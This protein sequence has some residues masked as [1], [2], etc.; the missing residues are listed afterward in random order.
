MKMITIATAAVLMFAGVALAAQ[1]KPVPK[2][3]EVSA[4]GCVEAGVEANCL[5]LKD[6]ASGKL[7]N[8]FIKGER[9]AVGDGI[10]F[11]GVPYDGATICMQGTA[12]QVAKWSKKDSL[13]CSEGKVHAY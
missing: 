10:E 4:S 1:E 11:V 2:P 9:P 3:T 5:V 8:I 12:V 13:K 7:Y 6:V